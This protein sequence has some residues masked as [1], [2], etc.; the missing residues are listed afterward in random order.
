[1][2]YVGNEEGLAVCVCVHTCVCDYCSLFWELYFGVSI[3]GT[4]KNVHLCIIDCHVCAC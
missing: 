4:L 3:A 2:S 1:M